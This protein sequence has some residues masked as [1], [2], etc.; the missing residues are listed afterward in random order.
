[1]NEDLAKAALAKIEQ[2]TKQRDELAGILTDILQNTHDAE[3]GHVGE[4]IAKA[5]KSTP[6]GGTAVGFIDTGL[7]NKALKQGLFT[8]ESAAVRKSAD[9]RTEELK[10]RS[11]LGGIGD[12]PSTLRT[13]NQ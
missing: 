3:G 6:H 9:D 7:V 1:M 4:A 8:P 11:G 13:G 12:S 2:L 10:K 5:L